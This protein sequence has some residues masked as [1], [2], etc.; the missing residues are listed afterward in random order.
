VSAGG[1][2]SLSAEVFIMKRWVLF[3]A[4]AALALAGSA[5]AD[6]IVN[7]GFENPSIG[8][9]SFAIFANG[10]V[11]GWTSNN[12]ELE[13]DSNLILGTPAPQGVQSAELNGT[14][15]D[16]ITQTVTG[17]TAGQ[18]YLLSYFYGD[19]GGGGPQQT[20]VSFGGNLVATNTGTG[21]VPGVVW[22]PHSVLV[23]ASASSEDL[24]FA[25]VN[26]GGSSTVGNELD[27]VSLV[28]VPEPASLTLLGLGAVGVA[29][30]GWRR[31]K[32]A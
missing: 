3:L 1:I 6:F 10:G 25:A 2:L 29:G 7:G 30:Y 19:R 8:P 15:Y 18:Q 22:T 23:T 31:R 14:T 13:I 21:S 32:A 28:A 17:L 4:V 12:N 27:G 20:D 16:T 9:N 24:S 5:R 26:V 11:P